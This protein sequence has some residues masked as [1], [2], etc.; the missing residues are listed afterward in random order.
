MSKYSEIKKLLRE[1][2]KDDLSNQRLIPLRGKVTEITGQSCKVKLHTGLEI[3]EIKLKAIV[4]DDS[5]YLL[6]VPAIDS[7]V[8]VFD[9]TIISVDK[10]AKFE[11]SQSGLKIL[12]DSEDKKV[13]IANEDVN[14]LDALMELTDILKNNYKQFTANGPTSGTLPA[15]I[16][17]IEQ[18]EEKFKALLK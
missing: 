1:I 7:D 18:N 10:V 15:S 3:S 5:D 12:F 17:A 13:K 2:V 14:L 11:F 9:D 4:T 6:I 8:L 16:Q